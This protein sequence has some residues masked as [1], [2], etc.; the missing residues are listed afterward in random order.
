MERRPVPA[1][2]GADRRFSGIPAVVSEK[3]FFRFYGGVTIII[4]DIKNY[5][6]PR[7]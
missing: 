1:G 4:Y 7:E 3:Y 6:I 2:N 5:A